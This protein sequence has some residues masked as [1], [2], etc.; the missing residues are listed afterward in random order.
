VFPTVLL[1]STVNPALSFVEDCFY[2]KSSL[3]TPFLGIGL[4]GEYSGGNHHAAE[5]GF[6]HINLFGFSKCYTN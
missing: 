1:V 5:A 6:G 3:T 2:G 4:K